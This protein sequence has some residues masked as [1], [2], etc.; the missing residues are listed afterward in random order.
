[1]CI[2]VVG[3]TTAIVNMS[4]SLRTVLTSLAWWL[5]DLAGFGRREFI[6]PLL[7]SL[8]SAALLT[9]RP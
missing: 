9:I 5:G 1:M 3:A 2:S 6:G 8:V 4:R 7:T